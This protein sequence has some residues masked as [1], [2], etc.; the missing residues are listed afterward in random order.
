MRFDDLVPEGLGM[1]LVQLK[2]D[3]QAVTDTKSDNKGRVTT[4]KSLV[5]LDKR[6][7]SG[8]QWNSK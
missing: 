2:A 1:Y 6:I 5:N 4:G 3:G 7:T 8:I